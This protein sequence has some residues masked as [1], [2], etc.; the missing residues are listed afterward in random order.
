MPGVM[1]R[2]VGDAWITLFLTVLRTHFTA[3]EG[4]R[5]IPKLFIGLTMRPIIQKISS[6][7]LK[8]GSLILV[9]LMGFQSDRS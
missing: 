7:T 3:K 6:V 8:T 1:G 4:Y 5:L 2:P 9:G